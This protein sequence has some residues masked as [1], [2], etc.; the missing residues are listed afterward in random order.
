ML[1][2]LSIFITIKNT[3]VTF[4]AKDLHMSDSTPA[5]FYPKV[6]DVVNAAST[7]SDEV[8]FTAAIIMMAAFGALGGIF[9][10]LNRFKPYPITKSG[11]NPQ[12]KKG[13]VTEKDKQAVYDTVI[14][15]QGNKVTFKQMAAL[16]SIHALLGVGGAFAVQAVL[17][18]VGKYFALPNPSDLMLYASTCVISGF[19]GS[20]FLEQVRSKL[21][22]DLADTNRI[23]Q[24]AG[25]L[26]EE[27]TKSVTIVNILGKARDALRP[28]ALRSDREEAIELLAEFLKDNVTH[29]AAHI[30]RGRLHRANHDLERGVQCLTSYIAAK[31]AAHEQ[32]T[33]C[34]AGYYNRACYNALLNAAYPDK[35][36]EDEALKDLTKSLALDPASI[37]DAK[38]DPDLDSI[39]SIAEFKA[40]IGG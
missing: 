30:Y 18:S 21:E 26:A 17:I 32:D 33:D 40:L 10:F 9:D 25:A 39:S 5:Q 23:A 13:A 31:E 7:A 37:V 28:G 1:F 24:N 12:G 6:E 34:S 8:S 38:D 35:D 20:K 11:H 19:G 14:C 15:Y 16:C 27:A 36:Y 2:L 3:P 4:I 29:R 22:R